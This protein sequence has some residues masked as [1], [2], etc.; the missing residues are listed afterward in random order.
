MPENTFDCVVIGSG[1]GGSCAAAMLAHYGYKVL[2]VE[3][4]ANLG[5]RFSTME[6]DGVRCP[7]GALIVTCGTELE[8]TFEVTGAEFDIVKGAQVSWQIG[9]TVYPVSGPGA[10]KTLWALFTKLPPRLYRYAFMSTLRLFR[11]MGEILF[12]KFLNLFRKEEDYVYRRHEENPVTFR[13]W[14]EKYT[15]DTVVIQA[16]HAFISALFSAINDFECPASDV[17]AFGASMANPFKPHT[18]GFARYGNVELMK[19]LARVVT[20]NGGEVMTETEVKKITVQNGTVTG[21]VLAGPRGDFEVAARTVIS[22]AGPSAT[23]N[24]VGERHYPASYVRKLKQTMRPAPIV[25]GNIA[26]DVPLIDHKG[27][28]VITG[29]KTIVGAV[30]LTYHTKDVAPEGQHLL[31]TFA[32]PA[33]CTRKID[34]E[35]EIRHHMEDLETAFPL[36]KQHGRVLE[37]MVKDIDDDL[38]CL[39]TWPGYDMPVTTPIPNLFNVGD[40]VKDFGWTGC[41]ACAKSAWKV[42][43]KI[44]KDFP[45]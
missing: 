12:F 24:M 13:E 28:V 18:F 41:P 19:S 35:M 31:W 2:M 32:T 3:K 16:V 26:S 15:D 44:R 38:P 21:V 36:F 9:D 30:N 17:F 5:G 40:G 20:Q 23:M 8:K 42:V 22:N 39:R 4:R 10:L 27:L 29:T 14:I 33:T 6:I 7:T 1:V 34:K 25:M 37:L 11:A 43:K 45:L